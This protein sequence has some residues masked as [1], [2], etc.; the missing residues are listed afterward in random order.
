MLSK[1]QYISQGETPNKHLQN[2]EMALDAGVKLVQLRLKNVSQEVYEEF[3][4]KT[5]E[6]CSQYNSQLIINDNA[7]VA[8][9]CDADALHLGLTDMNVLEAREIFNK[10]IGG[11]A[12][13]FEHIKQRCL[14]KV[15]Y[16]GL[17][18]FK[19]TTTKDK[20]SPILGLNGYVEI[21]NKMKTENLYAP[22]YAIGGI[23]SQDIEFI[24]KTGVFGI[25]V[26]GLITNSTNK[27]EIINQIYTDLGSAQSPKTNI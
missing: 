19:F 2:I 14:E 13:T 25:A 24:M 8:K 9:V 12:N 27:K 16:I 21:I 26:S 22:I 3:A 17:G 7:L 15:D 1:L 10:K 5:K 6:L 18:P 23:E 4:C 20:L 11:T